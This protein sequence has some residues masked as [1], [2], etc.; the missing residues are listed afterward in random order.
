MRR[1]FDIFLARPRLAAAIVVAGG[2]KLK[3]GMKVSV[4]R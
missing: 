2:F 1:V 4:T 3:N